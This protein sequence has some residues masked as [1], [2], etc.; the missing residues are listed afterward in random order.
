MKKKHKKFKVGAIVVL[1]DLPEAG[2]HRIIKLVPGV[3][4]YKVRFPRRAV[5]G[6]IPKS[7]YSEIDLYSTNVDDI[8]LASDDE[9]AM[10]LLADI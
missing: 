2:P 4:E 3:D 6:R 5:L 1:R 7:G 9:A 10:G 8:R